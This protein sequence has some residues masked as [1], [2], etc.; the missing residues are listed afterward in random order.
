MSFR[1]HALNGGLLA[2]LLAGA[3][4]QAADPAAVALLEE[5]RAERTAARCAGC[6][7]A[8]LWLQD[9]EIVRGSDLSGAD[10]TGAR[11]A[12]ANLRKV[13]F[14]GAAM[15]GANMLGAQLDRADLSA[16]DLR[17]AD[18]HHV[19]HDLRV[20]RIVLVPA[21]VQ[22]LSGARER[23][24]RD[25]SDVKAAFD[26]PPGERAMVVAGRL[27]G[28]D[29]RGAELGEIADEAVVLFARVED[30]KPFAPRVVGKGDQDLV[31]PLSDIDGDEDG[32]PGNRRIEGHAR[33]L[34]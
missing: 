13:N 7:L 6:D 28:G 11:L 18:L 16:A 14:S 32:V 19:Q 22:G 25:Q 17:R 1:M 2:I 24:R 31:A 20:L 10:L 23:E 3:P 5:S 33:A 27:E 30:R 12:R 34:R 26:Q 8:A 29:D 9:G 21:V 15:T 4:A